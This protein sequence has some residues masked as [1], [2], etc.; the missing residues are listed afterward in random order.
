MLMTVQPKICG[1]SRAPAFAADE[2]ADSYWRDTR[3]RVV[4]LATLLDRGRAKPK[5]KLFSGT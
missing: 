3:E 2:S 1:L 5:K 4:A